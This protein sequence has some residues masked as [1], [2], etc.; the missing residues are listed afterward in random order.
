MCGIAGMI[1]LG[2]KRPVPRSAVRAM[3]A[4]LVHRGPDEDGY[5]I[6][7][8]IALASRR[9]S[10]IGLA[11]GRQPIANETRDV[12]VVFNGEL[13]DYREQRAELR[14]RG[15]RLATQ[16]DTELV[17]H[18]WEDH[19]EGMF[20]RLRGQF[21]LALWDAGRQRLILGR[22]RFGICPLYWARRDNWLLFASEI[23]ALLASGLI[24]A[25]VDLQGLNHLFTF[26]ALPG[27]VTCFQGIRLLLPGHYLRIQT[28]RRVASGGAPASI[29]DRTYWEIDFP[30]RGQESPGRM[31]QLVDEFEA[32]LL[33]AVH[34]RLQA[35]VPVVSY[36]PPRKNCNM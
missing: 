4:A 15:H 27:P 32:L 30:E 19:Q 28:G 23:K 20:E 3:A 12:F 13:F 16:C 11:D 14:G 5:L 22:D 34:R 7:P 35:D 1:D 2:G 25:Q 9:L 6:R 24:T 31:P 36:G 29:E 18:L 17:P 26:F 10:I 21:A 8:G 33:R